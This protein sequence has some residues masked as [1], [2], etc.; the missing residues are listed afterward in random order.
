MRRAV[1][2]TAVVLVLGALAVPLVRSSG[3]AGVLDKARKDYVALRYLEAAS[4]AVTTYPTDRALAREKLDRALELAPDE[5]V[6][7]AIAPAIYS[8]L[9]DYPAMARLLA[10]QA[11]PN[12]L[13]LG[14]ALLMTGRREAGAQLLLKAARQA[15]NDY[16][17]GRMAETEYALELNNIGYILA[18][19]GAAL[20]EA[21]ALLDM[22][23]TI[24]PLEPNFVDSLGW[25]HYRLGDFRKAAF[26]L[27]RA[28]RQQPAPGHAEIYYH[29]GAAYARLG[30][31]QQARQVL[32]QALKLDP[33]DPEANRELEALKWVLPR[34]AVA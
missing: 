17:L 13:L 30:R 10:R 2:P 34:P 7:I 29:L 4:R 20:G 1:I 31:P 5:P 28:A 24:L 33:Q 27:E 22:A 12:P 19:G 25:A 16:R 14:E 11:S 6:V 26:F 23:T 21:K 3:L 32:Q 9:G 18:D 15:H 8:A